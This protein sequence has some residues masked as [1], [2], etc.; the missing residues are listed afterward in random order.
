MP[1]YWPGTCTFGA[2]TL[3]RADTAVAGGRST[4]SAWPA[5]TSSRCF[6]CYPSSVSRR[7]TG[8]LPTEWYRCISRSCCSFLRTISRGLDIARGSSRF[9]LSGFPVATLFFLTKATPHSQIGYIL[10]AIL[11][12]HLFAAW[13]VDRERV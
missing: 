5:R 2:R 9:I 3:L 1:S 7:S 12:F 10:G 13:Y 4:T 11:I 6:R 8:R